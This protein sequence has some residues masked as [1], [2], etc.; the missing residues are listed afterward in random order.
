MLSFESACSGVGWAGDLVFV[1]SL[2]DSLALVAF[3]GSVG[4]SDVVFSSALVSLFRLM[5]TIQS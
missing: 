5:I 1:F 2:V 3:V 4:C